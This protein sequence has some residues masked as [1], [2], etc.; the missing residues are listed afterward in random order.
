MAI[1]ISGG[2]VDPG[3]PITVHMPEEPH[4]KLKPV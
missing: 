1:V 4:Q 3:D 2:Q